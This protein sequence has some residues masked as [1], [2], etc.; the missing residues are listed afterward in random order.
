[1]PGGDGPLTWMRKASK[2]M[3][4]GDDCEGVT[5]V[6][7]NDKKNMI[8]AMMDGPLRWPYACGSEN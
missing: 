7:V 4:G 3:A 6:S 1:M 5:S 8:A 2:V